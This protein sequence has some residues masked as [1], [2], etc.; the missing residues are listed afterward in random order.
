VPDVLMVMLSLAAAGAFATMTALA[1]IASFFAKKAG[2][3]EEF[4]LLSLLLLFTTLLFRELPHYWFV[5]LPFAAI[6][7]A[8]AFSGDHNVINTPES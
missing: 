1:A 2:P 6:L 7:C 8:R 3:L 4:L 5:G